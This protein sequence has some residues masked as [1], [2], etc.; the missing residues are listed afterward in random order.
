VRRIVFYGASDIAEIA[1]VSLQ[2]T[3]IKLTAVVDDFKVGEK[4][5]GTVVKDCLALGR[6][7]FDKLLV[8]TVEPGG[9][10]LDELQKRG[11]C[12]ERVDL[13]KLG[14]MEETDRRK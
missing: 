3:P 9:N 1:F 5:L 6:I 7:P 2:E 14:P 8:T 10:I 11:V 4:F 13:L 12:R